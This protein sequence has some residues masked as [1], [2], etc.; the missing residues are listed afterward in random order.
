MK[1]IPRSLLLNISEK[2]GSE[3]T[4]STAYSLGLR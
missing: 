4:Q 1:G 2:R 3:H